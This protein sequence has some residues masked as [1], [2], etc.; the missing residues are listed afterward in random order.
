ML[1]PCVKMCRLDEEARFC[2]GCLRTLEE[3]RDWSTMSDT[4]RRD[5]MATL[6]ERQHVTRATVTN[7]AE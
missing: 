6:E 5:V 2:T 3:I 7:G 1:S 4:Q